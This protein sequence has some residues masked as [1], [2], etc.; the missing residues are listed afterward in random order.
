[1]RRLLAVALLAPLIAL[2]ANIEL[3]PK[4]IPLPE[5]DWTV[6][7]RRHWTGAMEEILPG[8]AFTGVYMVEVKDGRWRR[9]VQAMTNTE[10]PWKGWRAIDDPCHRRDAALAYRDLSASFE[11][12]FCYDV[13]E[14]RGYMRSSTAWRREAQ[15]WLAERKV[16]LPRTVYSVRFARIDRQFWSEV[17][18]YFDAADCPGDTVQQKTQ[19]L[20]KWAAETAPLVREGLAQ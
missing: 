16:L 5:G 19:A 3:G 15:K 1:V 13:T 17:S 4:T 12:Q 6:V 14:V 8:P 10:P 7:A 18:Y 11:D 20:M 2:A 9:A